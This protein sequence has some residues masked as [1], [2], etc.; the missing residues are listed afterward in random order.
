MFFLYVSTFPLFVEHV[1]NMFHMCSYVFLII[2]HAFV[3]LPN[4]NGVHQR[5]MTIVST[6]INS[7][8]CL[9]FLSRI[10]R[11]ELHGKVREKVNTD[12]TPQHGEQ[13]KNCLGQFD[14]FVGQFS[15]NP[16]TDIQEKVRNKNPESVLI[17]AK[18]DQNNTPSI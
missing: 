8:I 5:C 6:I 15:I 14:L 17:S 12:V 16:R 2:S 11:F 13:N 3:H 9:D 18:N 1:S 10:E 7:L 4:D